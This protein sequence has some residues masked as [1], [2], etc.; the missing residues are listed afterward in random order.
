MIDL[1][2]ADEAV[3]Y[4]ANRIGISVEGLRP[5]TGVAVTDGERLVGGY[6]FRNYKGFDVEIAIAFE[7]DRPK[8]L[9]SETIPTVFHYV[10]NEL[11][12]ARATCLIRRSNKESRRLC[13]AMDFKLEGKARRGYDGK[14]DMMIYGL[15]R[16]ECRWLK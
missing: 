14:Q 7:P 3:V 11:G 6:V 9:I 15:L 10:F 2:R 12:C 5:C 13:E 8:G 4:V 1:G 16:D